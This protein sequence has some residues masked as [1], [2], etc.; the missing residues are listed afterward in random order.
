MMAEEMDLFVLTYSSY[1]LVSHN[2]VLMVHVTWGRLHVRI[3]VSIHALQYSS[4]FLPLKKSNSL[5]KM[6]I[7]SELFL[8][9]KRTQRL[10]RVQ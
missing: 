2:S 5:I 3:A 10:F 4:V 7:I 9:I 1:F 8:R 6:L